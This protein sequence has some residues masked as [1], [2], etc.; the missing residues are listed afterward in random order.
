MNRAI[1]V[2][3]MLV[4]WGGAVQAQVAPPP[5]ASGSVSNR[6]FTGEVYA[7]YYGGVGIH[8][9]GTI[10]NFA[11]GLPLEVRLG[12]GYA[13]VPTGDAVRARRVFIDQA[14]NGS[15][16]SRGKMWDARVDLLY[17][18]KL[19][20]LERSRLFG[21][22][23]RN[24]YTAY[25]EYIGGNE[26]FDVICNQWGAGG[27]LETAFA[28]SPKVDLLLTTGLDYYF[29]ATMSGHDT[30]YRPNGD[31]LNAKEDFTYRDAD[32]TINQPD[33]NSRFMLGVAYRF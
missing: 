22:L 11:Q 13:W 2:M 7:G 5:A 31:D 33:L 1:A 15:P 16:R 26:T 30:Y 21:G 10:S 3:T 20:G 6:F 19:F 14:T 8:A 12:L 29:R 28:V 18:V 32:A 9:C 24:N 27:G 4:L 23:R 25:F 17:P